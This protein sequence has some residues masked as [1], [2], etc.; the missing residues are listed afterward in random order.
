[1]KYNFP[2]LKNPSFLKKF[3]RLKLKEQYVK[4]IVLTF[5]EKPLQQIEGLVTGGSI[6]LD[7]SS[8]MRRTCNLNLIVDN[9]E[10]NPS[11]KVEYILG[12]NKKIDVLIGFK[13]TTNE[14]QNFPILWFPQGTY[15]IIAANFSHGLEGVTIA[16]TLHDKMAFLNGEC[17]GTLP[18]SVTFS[19]V[20]DIDENGETYIRQPTIYEII[21]QLVNHFGGEQ[22][23]KII[24]SD[25]DNKVKQVVKWTGSF[26]I[27]LYQSHDNLNTVQY[28]YTTNYND[29]IINKESN[30]QTNEV[31]T[32]DYTMYSYG[33]DIG[34]IYTD[35]TYPGQLIGNAGDTVVT[36]LDQIKNIL[37]NYEYFYDVEGNFRFQEIKN[38]LNNSYSTKVSKQINKFE[39]NNIDYIVDFID[40]KSVYTFENGEIIQSYSNSPNY[41][42]IK[43]DFL[44]WGVRK[45]IEGAQIPI[46]YHLAIDQ[47]PVFIPHSYENITLFEDPYDGI[48]KAK[49][50]KVYEKKELFPK[51]GQETEFYYDKQTQTIFSWNFKIQEYVQTDLKNLTFQINKDTDYRTDLF[52]AGVVS[53]STGINSNPYYVELKNEW[54][55][56][57]DLQKLYDIQLHNREEISQP[58]IQQNEAFKKINSSDIDYFLDIINT[59]ALENFNIKNIGKRTTTIVDDSINCIFEP[60][61]P[62]IIIIQKNS[63][64]EQEEIVAQCENSKQ[65]YSQVTSSIYSLIAGGGYLK[66]AY[67]QIRKELYQYINYGEQVNLTT[68]PIFYLEPNTR[69]TI[70]DNDSLISG[71]F[72]I[73][74]ISLPLDINGT[75]SISC[76]KALERI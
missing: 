71:D 13:N 20:E 21:Q 5:D 43:N 42:Q 59:P 62:D 25:I 61:P 35:F 66:S 2:Y 74:S 19:Q 18:A 26:P 70:Q 39:D 57:F 11:K 29:L 46:R 44:V 3:D 54:P 60:N 28:G 64:Q 16:L 37:G 65:N 68:L 73:K 23:G 45:T 48:V 15:A 33:D 76:I 10:I 22:L 27:Y 34:Y 69:I 56:L 36:I 53:Q 8:G 9:N 40:G 47:K 30:N 32:V 52:F 72:I 4:I 55:K 1:M 75:M 58:S 63:G 12:L 41:L 31:Q 7:G 51:I 38:Y 17:G 6:S 24:I 50:L 67:E 49:Y 14:Y